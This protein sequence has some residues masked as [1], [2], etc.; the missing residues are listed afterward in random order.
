MDVVLAIWLDASIKA[1]HFVEAD[2]WRQNMSAMR[3]QYLPAS[4]NY[5]YQ[6]GSGEVIG[7]FSLCD[8]S[9]AAIF[10]SPSKQG[11]GV[12]S[13]LLR[14]AKS[15]RILLRLTVYAENKTS[16]TFYKNAGF[17]LLAEQVDV[18]TGQSEYLMQWDG[19]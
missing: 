9:L 11:R 15:L 7:F 8:D 10:V 4:E 1:H 17:K 12:G 6:D 3:D 13:A 19:D 16:V 14:H 5:V 18:H 2:V